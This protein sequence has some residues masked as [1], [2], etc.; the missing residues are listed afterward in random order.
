MGKSNRNHPPSS[1]GSRSQDD[2]ESQPESRASEALTVGWTL[3]A[4]TAFLCDV[5]TIG[6]CWFARGS[7]IGAG[8]PQ[9]GVPGSGAQLL[10]NLLLFAGCIV[11]ALSLTLPPLVY[12]VRRTP[13]PRSVAIFG[14][15][16]AAAP[17]IVVV[18]GLG[19]KR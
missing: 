8:V 9:G 7:D 6:A 13:P 5:G 4:T 1:S 19:F 2:P 12:K 17:L 15:L 3:T 11:G 14:V 10:A 18:W 16:V